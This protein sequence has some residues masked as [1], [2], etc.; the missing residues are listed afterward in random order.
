VLASA[1][2]DGFDALLDTDYD[3]LREMAKRAN[4]PP[5]QEF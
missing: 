3:Q 5:Y 4:M 1:W 2:I